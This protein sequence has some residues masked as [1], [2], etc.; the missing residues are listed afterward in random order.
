[1]EAGGTGA[2]SIAEAVAD[3]DV[4]ITIVPDSPDVEAV[5]RR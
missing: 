5:A 2:D 3:A 1:M 4:I